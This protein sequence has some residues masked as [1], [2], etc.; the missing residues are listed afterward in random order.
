MH[1]QDEPVPAYNS[2]DITIP[3]DGSIYRPDVL[4]GFFAAIRSSDIEGVTY[5]LDGNPWLAQAS[6][7]NGMLPLYVATVAGNPYIVALLAQRGA[8]I[9]ELSTTGDYHDRDRNHPIMRTPLMAAALQGSLPLVKL[10]FIDLHA[11]DTI[12]APDGAIALRLA[13]S[14]NHAEIIALL[15]SRR[16]GGWRR[17]KHSH[18]KALRRIKAA[19]YALYQYG[20]FFVWDMPK[21]F[22]WSI[23]KYLLWEL[24]LPPIKRGWKQLAEVLPYLPYMAINQVKWVGR[25]LW[26]VIRGLPSFCVDFVKGC[27]AVVKKIPSFCVEF[28][29]GCWAVVKKILLFCVE[30]AK[31]WWI[32]AEEITKWLWK[33]FTTT[34]PQLLLAMGKSAVRMLADTAKFMLQFLKD[35]A[36]FFHTLIT[37]IITRFKAVTLKDVLHAL[38]VVFVSIP[39]WIWK[40]T[41]DTV[42]AINNGIYWTLKQMGWFVHILVSLIW[43][44]ILWI[45]KKI[46][47]IV[48]GLGEIASAGGREVGIWI[49]PKWRVGS[50]TDG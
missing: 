42:I 47:Q 2:N 27:W 49:N 33:L 24:L 30:F 19:G 8:P 31:A 50:S 12:V 10:L 22:L 48:V 9:D 36:S 37:A 40:T 34:I 15:P 29:K 26:R 18:R 13:V 23:P 45:P 3:D 7:K 14:R 35:V 21:F 17:F 41:Q 1:N 5:L 43:E 32:L 44:I 4:P 11:D 20:R 46:G 28:A 25:W 6:D 39:K 38:S 16:H